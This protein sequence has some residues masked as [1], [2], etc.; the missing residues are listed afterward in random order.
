MQKI[1]ISIVSHLQGGIVGE[2]L[3]DIECFGG[4][5]I[6][7]LLTLNMEEVVPLAE[8]KF[9]YPI[10]IIHNPIPKGFAANHNHA[11]THAQGQFFCVLNPDIRLK[12]NPFKGLVT[13]LQNPSMGVVAPV[14]L[15]KSGEIEDSARKFPTPLKILCKAFGKCQG[16]DYLV[17]DETVF[18]D[19]VGGMFMLFR[20]ETF[21]E[22]GGFNERYFLYYEDV[23]LCARLRLRGYEVA[24]CPASKV[25]HHAQ[26]SSHRNLKYLRWHVTS[27]LRFFLSYT[28][29]KIYWLRMIRRMP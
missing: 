29:I 22:L 9:S 17:K 13:T 21:A 25:V 19:W 11:F 5:N 10:Q 6:E 23:D 18:P 15:T 14:V 4:N 2:L 1:S 8:Q 7:V 24:I 16:G 27:M 12:S 20:R 28:F 26:R 3:S